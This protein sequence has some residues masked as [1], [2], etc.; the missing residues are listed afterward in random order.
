MNLSL[1]TLQFGSFRSFEMLPCCCF[2]GATR[3]TRAC[4]YLKTSFSVC[5]CKF[6][7]FYSSIFNTVLSIWL[8]M[9]L[10]KLN[11]LYQLPCL[12]ESRQRSTP[13]QYHANSRA[14]LWQYHA[15]GMLVSG[16]NWKTSQDWQKDECSNVQKAPGWKPAS[17]YSGSQTEVRIWSTREWLQ[18]NSANI[19][20]GCNQIP[21]LNLIDYPC[22][23]QFELSLLIT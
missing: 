5:S 15:V 1:T 10:E 12:E 22:D 17:S 13:A 4:G 2:N 14:Q 21:N 9:I 7:R 20:E 19:L 23:S 18:D 11:C 3:S 16:R 8:D 6:L